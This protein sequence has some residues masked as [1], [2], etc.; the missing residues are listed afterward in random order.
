MTENSDKA[1]IKM[2]FKPIAVVALVVSL[3]SALAGLYWLHQQSATQQQTYQQQTQQ[4]IIEMIES[5]VESRLKTLDQQLSTLAQS[6]QLAMLLS[7]GD[8]SLITAQQRLMQQNLPQVQKICLIAAHIDKPNPNACIPISFATLSS[9]RQA[10]SDG[11]AA[12]TVLQLDTQQPYLL[13]AHRITDARDN[14]LG[15]LLATFDM[16]NVEN[17]L[18]KS[19]GL[20]GYIE[21]QQGMKKTTSLVSQGNKAWKRGPAVFKKDIDQSHWSIAYWPAKPVQ[22]NL[23]FVITIAVLTIL[24]LM[25]LLMVFWQHRGLRHDADVLHQQVVDLKNSELKTKYLTENAVLQ[26][27]AKDILSLS[28]SP[29]ASSN[30]KAKPV[31]RP[32]ELEEQAIEVVPELVTPTPPSPSQQGPAAAVS[33]QQEISTI[34][35]T[36]FKAYDIRGIV[37]ET[38]NESIVKSIGQAIGSQALDQKQP[39]LIVARDGRLS[40]ESFANALIE[41]ILSSGCDVID[42]GLVPTPVAYFAYEHIGTHSGVVVTGSHNPANYNGLKIV[43]DGKP[44]FGASLQQLYQRI[45]EGNVRTGQGSKKQLSVSDDYIAK[46]A[47]DIKIQRP[48][49]VVIDC[50]NGAA[51]VVAV[52]LLSQLGCEVTELYCDV[53]GNFPN[54][55]PNPC[56][57]DNL[58]DLIN[59]VQQQDAELGLAFDGDG[60]RI[61]AVDVKGQIIWPDRLMIMFAQDVL[62]QLPGSTIIYDVKSSRLLEDAILR[63]GG[64]PLMWQSGHSVLRNKMQEM[65]APLA[66]EMSGHIFFKDRWFGFD[67][68]LYSA[69]RLLEILVNDPLERTP[70]E[71]FEAIPTRECTPEIFLDMAEGE[72]ERFMRQFV[73]EATFSG[74][75]TTTIDGLRADFPMGW[76]LVRA[77]NTVPGLTLRFEADTADNLQNIQQQFKQ[78][79]LQ[80]KPTL[81]LDF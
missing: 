49:R 7:R 20:S 12:M 77:S 74:A 42:I 46:V 43:L 40:S 35:P 18:H 4:Q 29:S 33:I 81:T 80:I 3:L 9:L 60:D 73:T 51:G 32:V 16:K 19:Y 41:G 70:T 61:V 62:T 79:I 26:G 15:V 6:P 21:L 13:T 8:A 57:P 53:D 75:K 45:L 28:H 27:V 50:A 68:A 67:D 36:I 30:K 38:L 71:V 39:R 78:Q 14:V 23:F 34:S 65:D 44:V 11:T 48:I 54:H 56:D 25:W 47:D 22:P 24:A 72:S 64:E 5:N 59:V 2:G 52:N 37:G 10:K 76:G 55:H 58:K 63:S 1:A 69:C 66:G 31:V 17:M